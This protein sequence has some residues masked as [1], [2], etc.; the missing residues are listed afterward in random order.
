MAEQDHVATIE[1]ET[2]LHIQKHGSAQPHKKQHY[3]VRV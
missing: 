2:I 1:A 3:N